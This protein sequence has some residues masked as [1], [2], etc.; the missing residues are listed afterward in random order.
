MDWPTEDPLSILQDYK[1]VSLMFYGSKVMNG[2]KP[3][4]GINS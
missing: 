1:E 2:L 3:D 4:N